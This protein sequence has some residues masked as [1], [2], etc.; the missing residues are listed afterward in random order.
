MHCLTNLNDCQMKSVRN[1]QYI[2]NE[3][4]V[5]VVCLFGICDLEIHQLA[6]GWQL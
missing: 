1:G 3:S 2:V 5:L 4:K 6:F